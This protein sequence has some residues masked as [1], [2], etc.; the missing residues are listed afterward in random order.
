[1]KGRGLRALGFLLL[2]CL[3]A[4]RANNLISQASALGSG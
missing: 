3:V 2:A 4:T 1:M